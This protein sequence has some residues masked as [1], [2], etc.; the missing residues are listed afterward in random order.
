MLFRILNSFG[1]EKTENNRQQ[2]CVHIGQCLQ[3]TR[4]KLR[5]LTLFLDT[6]NKM[7]SFSS[8]EPQFRNVNV[9]V[10]FTY[11]KLL[12]ISVTSDLQCFIQTRVLCRTALACSVLYVSVFLVDNLRGKFLKR[13]LLTYQLVHTVDERGL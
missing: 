6:V 9:L 12:T 2:N 11:Y 1:K 10:L 8:E 3:P 4:S 5:Q 7:D 13:P